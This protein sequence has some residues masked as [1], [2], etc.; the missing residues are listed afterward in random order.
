L[1]ETDF[2]SKFDREVP[3]Y[4]H[5]ARKRKIPIY[6]RPKEKYRRGLFAFQDWAVLRRYVSLE[7]AKKAVKALND[8]DEW[9][10]YSVDPYRGD[11][12]EV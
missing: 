1:Q 9:F 3:K 12:Y 2:Q 11:R 6:W 10:E 4:R 7:D 8:K 5:K